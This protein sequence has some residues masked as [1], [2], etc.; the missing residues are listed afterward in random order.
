LAAVGYRLDDLGWFQF[1]RMCQALLRAKYGAS[2]EA[3]GGS[4]DFG[5][6]AYSGDRLEFPIP[7]RINDGP[8]VFQVKFIANANAPGAKLRDPLRSAVQSEMSRISDR[9]SN[10]LWQAPQ[11]YALLTNAPLSAANRKNLILLI[12]KVLPDAKIV[13]WGATDVAASLDDSPS[14][15]LSYP[16]ILGLRDLRQLLKTAV[17]ADVL[18][19]S[20][21]SL[22]ITAQLAQVFV[23][24]RA[25][26]RAIQILENFGFAVLTGPPEMGK[27]ATAWMIALARFTNSWEAFDCRSPADV[28]RVY[29]PEK[30]QIFIA[31]DAFGSTEYRPEIAS[32]WAAQLDKIVA[33][34]GPK[35]WVIW[36]SRPG[37]LKIG[38]ERLHLV[39]ASASFPDPMRVQVDA[40]ILSVIEKSQILYR[41]AKSAQLRQDAID[42]VKDNAESIVHSRHFTPLR[43]KRLVKEQIPEVMREEPSER[44]YALELAVHQGLMEPSSAMRTSFSMLS[45]EVRIFLI[46]ML[47]GSNGTMRLSD[48]D[49]SIH[50]WCPV[51]P[52]VATVRLRLQVILRGSESLCESMSKKGSTYRCSSAS[53]GTG[54]LAARSTSA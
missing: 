23:A 41:H 21:I 7:K 22:D 35:H 43:I 25:Y 39:G 3:W 54:R 30:H 33:L 20:T 4:Q 48:L 46:S 18:A 27:T 50:G 36:T 6:D 28:F 52:K 8:F 24:T 13:L 14:I 2:L 12:K 19:R 34:C 10:G 31:D 5:R 17:S 9:I 53:H 51:S 32:E 42:L 37:P 47:N 11:Y 45:E 29:D 16:Q 44:R 38:L 15:R 1:E 49:V 26:T 40:S